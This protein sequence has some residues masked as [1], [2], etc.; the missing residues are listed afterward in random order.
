MISKSSFYLSQIIEKMTDHQ[1][2]QKRASGHAALNA[3]DPI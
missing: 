1:Q 2:K 3:P